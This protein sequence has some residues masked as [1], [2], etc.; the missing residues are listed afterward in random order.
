MKVK[1]VVIIHCRKYSVRLQCSLLLFEKNLLNPRPCFSG[2]VFDE[3]KDD[4]DRRFWCLEFRGDLG[5]GPDS[6][7]KGLVWELHPFKGDSPPIPCAMEF[8]SAWSRCCGLSMPWALVKPLA[9]GSSSRVPSLDC[10]LLFGEDPN[11]SDGG[12]NAFNCLPRRNMVSWHSAS[13]SAAAAISL[14]CYHTGMKT[15]RKRSNKSKIMEY[16]GI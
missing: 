7:S 5:M 11:D 15:V 13:F 1:S 14:S 12:R 2:N 16:L 9:L 8:T 3:E 6:P 4:D 10:C